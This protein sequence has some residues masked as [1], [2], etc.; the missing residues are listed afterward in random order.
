MQ[1]A[2]WNA[3]AQ[4]GSQ[5]ISLASLVVLTRLLDPSDFG[6]LSMS[7]L[8]ISFLTIFCEAGLVSALIQKTD[9]TEDDRCVAFW[10]QW[11]ISF[12]MFLA[13]FASAPLVATFFKDEQLVPV[14]RWLSILFLLMPLNAIP[15]ALETKKIQYNVMAIAELVSS[16]A[17]VGTSIVMAMCGMGLWS[18]VGHELVK[19]SSRGVTLLVLCG[20]LPALRFSRKSFVTLYHIG[21]QYTFKNLILYAAENVEGLLIGRMLGAAALGSYGIGYRVPSYPVMK[22]WNMFGP[23]LFPVFSLMERGSERLKVNL[24]RVSWLGGYFLIPFIVMIFFGA[25]IIIDVVFGDK[26]MQVVPLVRIFCVDMAV[27]AV[28]FGDE[29]MLMALGR[30]TRINDWK[31]GFFVGVLVTGYLG[32]KFGGLVGITACFV[33][34]SMVNSLAIKTLTFRAVGLKW[35]QFFAYMRQVWIVSTVALAAHWVYAVFCRS[36]GPKAFVVGQLVLTGLIVAPYILH[37]RV[38]DFKARKLNLDRIVTLTL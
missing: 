3:V 24:L 33:F 10:G 31:I 23:M 26:W 13:V 4:Y 9:V 30:V 15:E 8:V 18:L 12:F 32:I 5:V 1:G 6:A 19:R 28:S 27:T 37:R 17:G 35:S 7:L 2:F 11:A 22:T 20:W 14:T 34:C 38:L 25:E 36:L 16:A 21:K 29:S